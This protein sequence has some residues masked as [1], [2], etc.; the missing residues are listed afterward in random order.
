M[1]PALDLCE[2]R[3]SLEGS[4]VEAPK[5]SFRLPLESRHLPQSNEANSCGINDNKLPFSFVQ[6]K[7][8]NLKKSKNVDAPFEERISPPL[9]PQVSMAGTRMPNVRAV[10]PAL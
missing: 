6:I 1:A 5:F 3:T 2:S 10:I 8:S 4:G 7:G 9:P